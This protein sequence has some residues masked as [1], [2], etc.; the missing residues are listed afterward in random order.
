MVNLW[1][2]TKVVDDLLIKDCV[3]THSYSS[4]VRL[5]EGKIRVKQPKT[6]MID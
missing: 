2:M 5:P 3:F 1:K 4:Y 6:T